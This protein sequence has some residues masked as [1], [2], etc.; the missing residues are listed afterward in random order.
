MQIPTRG[1]AMAEGRR[2][3]LCL[4]GEP[5]QFALCYGTVFCPVS[6]YVGVLWPNGWMDQGATWYGGRPRPRRHCVRWRPSYPHGKGHSSSPTFRPISIVTK[7]SPISATV[8]L[9]LTSHQLLHNCRKNPSWKARNTWMTFKV[10]QGHRKWHDSM[11]HVS[12]L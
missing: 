8:E 10:T 2:G 4:L 1:S 7:R 9:L 5:L 11:S 12:L 6:L 3:A